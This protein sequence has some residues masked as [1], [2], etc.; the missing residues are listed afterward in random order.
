MPA[1]TYEIKDAAS[2][3]SRWLRATFPQYKEIQTAYRVEAGVARVVPSRAVAF[4]T[5]GAAIDW[6]LRMLIDPAV[7]VDLAYTGLRSGRASCVR[8]GLEL[9][10]ALGGLDDARAPRPVQ[11]A[12]L[13][14]ASD[15]WWARAC[16]ALALLTELYRA[17]TVD[18]SRLMR[19]TADSKVEDLLAL[20]N[21]DEVADLIGLRNLA[22]E[23]LLPKL[24]AGPVAT[25]MTFDGSQDLNADA[26][27]IAGGVLVD[28]K[29]SQGRA[30]K[31]GTHAASLE[32]TELDQLLGY[33]L[34]DYSDKFAIHTVA[35]YSIRF[36]HL[37][38]WP[39]DELAMQMAG[40]RV[41]IA[42]LRKQFA[43]VLRVKLPTHWHQQKRLG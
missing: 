36:G 8:A 30:R 24:P 1:L 12:R 25:G 19:L 39:L 26:D 31:D 28:F 43:H 18:R 3:V 37:A 41:A 29:A 20:A 4:G 22:R 9:L 42:E 27:L 34:M 5:Q 13:A 10:V 40:R 6:W 16:Y 21:D 14:G 17:A 15:E 2:P 11:P 38:T 32:R 7:S 35:I 33:A 23:H